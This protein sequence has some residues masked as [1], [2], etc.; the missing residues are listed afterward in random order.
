MSA[1][2]P[3]PWNLVA[4]RAQFPALHQ[5][6]NGHPL[7]WLDSAATTQKP[8]AVLEAM[9]RFLREDN[10]NVHRGV[11]TLSQR[12][13][14]AYEG[15]RDKV[16]RF[17]NARSASEI[18]FTRGTTEAINLVA[19]S[20]GRSLRGQAVVVSGMEHHSNIVPW[21][22]LR[23]QAGVQVRVLP[24]DARGDLRL[25]LLDDLLAPPAAL[26]V[27]TH[28]SNAL[29]TVNPVKELVRRAHARGVRVLVDGAQA[30]AHLP[31]DVQDLDCDFYAFSGHKVYGPP[32]IGALYGK[33]QVLDAMPP[34]QG[35]G[36]MILSVDF[37][38]AVYHRVPYRFEAGTP[39]TVGAIGLGAALD[40]LQGQDRDAVRAHEERLLA[41]AQSALTDVP[42]LHLVGRPAQRAGALSFWVEGIHPHDVGTF[43]D[44]DGLA[45]RAGHHCAQPAL[46]HFGLTATTRASFGLYNA[47]EEVD[48]LAR[49]LR[50]VV[51][52]LG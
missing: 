31:V 14:E 38:R 9:D 10:A 21:L 12:A 33:A 40:W 42:R 52:V 19:S 44:Q 29:G 37:D 45:V 49:S 30:V 17:L 32:G 13:T 2:P 22:L 24:M 3:P 28:V 35:G 23:D 16:R 25:D 18:V 27:V 41:W 7:A 48:R 46:R 34:W 4:V 20:F 50:K 15:A 36:D 8:L 47:L 1:L 43:L 11:H 5:E 51:E 6:V 26:L 39:N